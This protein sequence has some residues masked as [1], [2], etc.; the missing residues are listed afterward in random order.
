VPRPGR[1]ALLHAS[2]TGAKRSSR[3]P[4]VAQHQR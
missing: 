3:A 2:P 1:R 4:R